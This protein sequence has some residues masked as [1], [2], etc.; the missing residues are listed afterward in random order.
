MPVRRLS[1]LAVV[2]AG[3][4]FMALS[5]AILGQNTPK[6]KPSQPTPLM[7]LLR[8]FTAAN[9]PAMGPAEAEVAPRK[10]DQLIPPGLPGNGLR[11]TVIMIQVENEIGLPSEPKEYRDR[12]PI[13]TKA[14]E[15]PVPKELMD[16]LQPHKDTL[17]PELGEV[18]KAA[19]SKASGT[20]EQVFGPGTAT[21]E[22]FMGWNYARY[23]GRVVD[24]GKAEYPLPM[25]MNAYTYGFAKA[26]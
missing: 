13:A 15:G 25:Y 10:W 18:W 5:P 14:Y 23:V 22:I 19:G 9:V 6:A 11:R 21:A 24:A 17:V 12:S 3:L 7:G 1:S 16:F 26:G 2:A 4:A 8:R 20:W